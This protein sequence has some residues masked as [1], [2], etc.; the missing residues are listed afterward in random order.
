MPN[1]TVDE[2]KS[3]MTSTSISFLDKFYDFKTENNIPQDQILYKTIKSQ[4]ITKINNY[5]NKKGLNKEEEKTK[6]YK[7]LKDQYEEITQKLRDIEKKHINV[8]Q[9]TEMENA[10]IISEKNINNIHQK[11]LLID[12][13][14]ITIETSTE[15]D[16]TITR[17]W[18]P[19]ADKEI[20]IKEEKSKGI[21][22]I[23]VPDHNQTIKDFISS[24]AFYKEGESKE[25]GNLPAGMVV[26]C[27]DKIIV[28]YRGT[29]NYNIQ[30][31]TTDVH[32]SQS[33]MKFGDEKAYIHAG[34]KSEYERS[35]KNR[36]AILDELNKDRKIPIIYT[37]HSMGA[38]LAQI[39][40]LDGTL[41]NNEKNIKSIV[42]AG[43]R[44]FSNNGAKLY[45]K[46]LGENTLRIVKENDPIPKILP[47]GIYSHAGFY[48]LTL[49]GRKHDINDSIK[50]F[51]TELTQEKLDNLQ[52][53][54][55]Q[56]SFLLR[57]A[58]YITKSLRQNI[59]TDNNSY[60]NNTTPPKA[61][62]TKNQPL[63]P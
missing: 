41:N 16:N 33:Q 6:R 53:K 19:D 34:F 52:S 35:K 22:L 32:F 60:G 45:N 61:K 1:F 39:A 31:L 5:L 46:H 43:P 57:Q 56:K 11:I 17:T 28:S 9:N 3:A 15:G 25:K 54:Q 63:T 44:V 12:E 30:E 8:H 48:K 4:D 27:K 49:S 14:K 58:H 36:D 40:A 51:S 10:K 26:K 47:K 7:L 13:K 38:A 42:L 2:V 18:I 37:G 55:N 20:F 50:K 29:E 24:T 59:Q 62:N 21:I 23:V